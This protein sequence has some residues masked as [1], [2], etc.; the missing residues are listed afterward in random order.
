MEAFRAFLEPS[1][2][3][4]IQNEGA[5][6]QSRPPRR[7][8]IRR[9]KNRPLELLVGPHWALVGSL[10]GHAGAIIMRPRESIGNE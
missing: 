10:F 2:G 6:I 1:G 3:P 8:P 4:S 7:R 5:G 9:P